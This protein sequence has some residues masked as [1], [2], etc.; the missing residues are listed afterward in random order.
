MLC[1]DQE[2]GRRGSL[3]NGSSRLT[4]DSQTSALLTNVSMDSEMSIDF[5]DLDSARQSSNVPVGPIVR[6]SRSGGAAALQELFRNPQVGDMELQSVSSRASTA[7]TG[8]LEPLMPAQLKPAK[9]KSHN[10]SK[11]EESGEK[12]DKRSPSTPSKPVIPKS[13]NITSTPHEDSSDSSDE[14]QTPSVETV[15]LPGFDQG[16]N[17][18]SQAK[19]ASPEK[20]GSPSKGFDA[21]F[22]DAGEAE[23]KPKVSL[24]RHKPVAQSFTLHGQP[25]TPEAAEAAGIPVI[26]DADV[27]N[28]PN[29]VQRMRAQ[30]AAEE[31]R[32]LNG[33]S[34]QRPGSLDITKSS[35]P[36]EA[37]V[38]I[39]KPS[40]PSP[41]T[42]FAQI[43]RQKE[44]GEVS[45]SV[46]FAQQGPAPK[47]GS[48]R[49]QFQKSK[50][51]KKTTFAALPNQ[52]T[53]RE[54]AAQ[55]NSVP[56]EVPDSNREGEPEATEGD[57]IQPLASELL[58]IRMRLAE[59]RRQM[60]GEKKRLEM[61][62]SKQRQRVGKQAFI[63]VISKNKDSAEKT[64][65][66]E[67]GEV[68][69]KGS[70]DQLMTK[71][72]DRMT[73]STTS[74]PGDIMTQSDTQVYA[75]NQ[76]KKRNSVER[77]SVSEEAPR[78]S[79]PV[80]KAKER[81]RSVS[82]AGSA[83]SQHSRE[84]SPKPKGGTYSREAIQTMIEGGRKRW[85]TG[86]RDS[87]ERSSSREK[88]SAKPQNPAV[89]RSATPRSRQASCGSPA[90]SSQGRE[91]P[92]S[93]G[94]Q[95][96]RP[97]TPM[98]SSLENVNTYN[99]SLDKL[100]CSLSELQGEIM[101]LS[102]QQD[103]IK[104]M[105][106]SDSTERPKSPPQSSS[107]SAPASADSS[108]DD[109][110]FFLYPRGASGG[111][112]DIASSVVASE[113]SPV[114][115]QPQP[116]TVPQSYSMHHHQPPV[117]YAPPPPPHYGQGYPGQY[118]HYIASQPHQP[119]SMYPQQ[120]PG[121]GY[122]PPMY[123]QYPQQPYPVMAP[124]P[125]QWQHTM[126][127][128][129][130]LANSHPAM[131][132]MSSTFHHS[133]QSHPVTAHSSMASIT[134]IPT[135]MVALD[136]ATQ[137]TPLSPQNM[138]PRSPLSAPTTP[139]HQHPAS[140]LASAAPLSPSRLPKEA[141]ESGAGSSRSDAEI[142]EAPSA[143]AAPNEG[144]FVSFDSTAPQKAKP[145]LGKNRRKKKD[146]K[147]EPQAP[148]REGGP[149]DVPSLQATPQQQIA[150]PPAVVNVSPGVGFVIGAEDTKSNMVGVSE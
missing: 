116:T 8:P 16:D 123:H 41:L 30:K 89:E 7:H 142:S 141:E 101:R 44:N 62:W 94:S 98:N 53:W 54:N 65:E 64:S 86:E 125:P 15:P 149:D 68:A 138:M 137:T 12:D 134:G 91:S 107:A 93:R 75:E 132:P 6:G 88:L 60:E 63:Q 49:D 124:G 114:L 34:S 130:H 146:S 99:T 24:D 117:Q 80:D 128:P 13:L 106:N 126:Q 43:K 26:T 37:A 96:S 56:R 129:M 150:P 70:D 76:R 3:Q 115:Q 9:E 27:S 28:V 103:Q 20:E 48:L 71:S 110:K 108:A 143:P 17:G 109:S 11:E 147:A 84:S 45:P 10:H 66:K 119:P 122:H 121:P 73:A 136:D 82:P 47:I 102:L 100:N 14:F 57:A 133:P 2:S 18:R 127:P 33:A 22:V 85:G 50:H 38:D 78:V 19:S 5:P 29:L 74:D 59:R 31:M 25:K 32:S 35:L 69:K 58:D 111:E 113:P 67:E 105:V 42:S 46:L 83:G 39:P 61:Q 23:N 104:T 145:Q 95:D 72:V 52:T 55:R 1:R 92:L 87:R 90:P 140:P 118:P 135:Q 40:D 131:P 51:P 139:S 112:P 144:F 148:S 21:F 4:T 77:L 79:P 97:R 120:Y 36:S 81:L